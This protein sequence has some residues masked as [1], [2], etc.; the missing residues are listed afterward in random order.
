MLDLSKYIHKLD[1]NDKLYNKYL[2]HKL[3]GENELITNKF[4]IDQMSKRKTSIEEFECFV[5]SAI[6]EKE[7][8]KKDAVNLYVCP[9]PE[10]HFN[11]DNTWKQHWDIGKCQN[12]VL[13]NVIVNNISLN[14]YTEDIFDNLVLQNLLKD[15]C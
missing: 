13:N 7:E 6:H 10:N 2:Q 12:K 8:L 4:L 15:E 9:K 1:K 14:N 11:V 5:C 3:G